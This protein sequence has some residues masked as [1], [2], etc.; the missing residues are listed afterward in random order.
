MTNMRRPRSVAPC[1]SKFSFGGFF[2]QAEDGIRDGHVTGVQ[3]CA[4]PISLGGWLGDKMNSHIILMYV[5][6]GITLSAILLSFAPSITW[7]SVGCLTIAFCAGLG[8]GVIFKLVPTY[9]QQQ[10]GIANGIV[11]ALGGLGGFF[12]PIILFVLFS[13]T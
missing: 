6:G 7:Y 3:T 11:S 5:F 4:L 2:F 1:L 8:N 12:P 9:F 10:A 13:I